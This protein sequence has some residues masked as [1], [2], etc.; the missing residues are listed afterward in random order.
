MT[1]REAI[2]LLEKGPSVQKHG[3]SSAD[4]KAKATALRKAMGKLKDSKQKRIISMLA[5]AI[6]DGEAKE[7]VEYFG[8]LSSAT[9][10]LW[11]AH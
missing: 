7:A 2:D 8:K 1:L 4:R 3:V 11:A 10:K 6:E 5:Q 9:K